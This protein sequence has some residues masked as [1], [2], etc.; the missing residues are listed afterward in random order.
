MR[1]VSS[2]PF[3]HLQSRLEVKFKG[4][5]WLY[6]GVVL[7]WLLSSPAESLEDKRPECQGQ[8]MSFFLKACGSPRSCMNA[9]AERFLPL[10]GGLVP[11]HI[12]M[13]VFFSE[14]C[15]P[16]FWPTTVLV[17]P[18]AC[19]HILF[20][21]KSRRKNEEIEAHSLHSSSH[22][23]GHLWDPDRPFEPIL[24]RRHKHWWKVFTYYFYHNVLAL[25][26][27]F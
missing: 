24:C 26:L 13:D 1:R 2:H 16:R 6:R 12:A 11:S 21:L 18:N 14:E 10:V 19:P 17:V 8:R 20:T 9:T 27:I 25:K 4:H 5:A 22:Q 7:P 15:F 23:A 3:P